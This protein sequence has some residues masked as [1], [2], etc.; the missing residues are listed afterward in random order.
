LSIPAG[1]YPQPDG[2]IPAGWYPRL[3][4]GW[5]PRLPAGLYG[6]PQAGWNPRLPAGWYPRLP[7]GWNPRPPEDCTP[8]PAGQGRDSGGELRTEHLAS[9]VPEA[10]TAL[11][12]LKKEHFAAAAARRIGVADSLGWGGLAVVVLIGALSL[13]L[14]GATM[15]FGL[16]SLVV[17]VITLARGQVGWARLGSRA[18]GGAALVAGLVA[19]TVGGLAGATTEKTTHTTGVPPAVVVS[20]SPTPST[21]GPTVPV[22]GTPGTSAPT[23]PVVSSPTATHLG[24]AP[25]S[26]TYS[27]GTTSAPKPAPKPAVAPTPART[28]TPAT[29]PTPTTTPATT[30]A[31]A[32][33]PATTPAT[34]PTPS[35]STTAL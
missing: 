23:V 27:P 8:Q 15:L 28:T 10:T 14:S 13:G 12:S 17:G 6:R 22:V 31:P 34:K 30:T 5:Y 25:T 29:S 3:P 9:G 19:M 18:A 11:T 33:T 20:D 4:A 24:V 1:W 7:A 2:H 16:F 21:S 35:N 26:P 32:T